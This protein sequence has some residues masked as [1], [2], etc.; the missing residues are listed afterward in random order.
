MIRFMLA[1]LLLLV[2]A[3]AA[4]RQERTPPVAEFQV[5]TL[6]AQWRALVPEALDWIAR[7]TSYNVRVQL[8]RIEVVSRAVIDAGMRSFYS[9]Y[10]NG[11][12]YATYHPATQTIRLRDD[13]L[14]SEHFPKLLHELVH[15]LQRVHRVRLRCPNE[16]ELEAYELENRYLLERNQLRGRVASQEFIEALSRCP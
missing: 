1:G 6:E 8:P 3:C 7:N 14:P 11:A 16:G 5:A 2:C 13:L 9:R 12:V 15:H 10:P 4:P